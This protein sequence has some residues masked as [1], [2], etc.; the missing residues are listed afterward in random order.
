MKLTPVIAHLRANCPTFAGRVAGAAQYAT[1][2]SATALRAPCAFVIPL[3][4]APESN[5]SKVG[6]RQ[7]ISESFGVVV[8][9][10]N[11]ADEKGQAAVD[12][13]H[14]LRSELWAALLNWPPADGYD[15]LDYQSGA[16]IDLDRHRLWWQF[17]FGAR[18]EIDSSD[19]YQPDRPHFE[20]VTV[21]V[22][23]IDPAADPN[24]SYPGPDGRIEVEVRIDD[25]PE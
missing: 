3:D 8:A 12:Q 1:S 14:D 9:V 19:G 21:S 10:S 13:I 4:D 16:L 17:E 20:G 18:T 6:V 22:D 24:L 2:K 5:G 23:V 25:L 7:Q 15:G 11:E